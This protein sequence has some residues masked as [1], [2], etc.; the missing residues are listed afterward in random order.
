[1]IKYGTKLYRCTHCGLQTT[2]PTE[3]FEKQASTETCADGGNKHE[4]KEVTNEEIQE[5]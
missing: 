2:M 1:M 4:L 5:I 3:E